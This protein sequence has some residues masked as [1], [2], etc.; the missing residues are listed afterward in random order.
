[1]SSLRGFA[2]AAG[3]TRGLRMKRGWRDRFGLGMNRIM[4]ISLGR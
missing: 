2:L 1:M 3:H 4:G